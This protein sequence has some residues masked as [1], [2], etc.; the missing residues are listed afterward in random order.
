MI[1]RCAPRLPVRRRDQTC[2]MPVHRRRRLMERDR[3]QPLDHRAL[4]GGRGSSPAAPGVPARPPPRPLCIA[5]RRA[6]GAS[7]GCRSS[8][9][10]REAEGY[11]LNLRPDPKAFVIGGWRTTRKPA[12]QPVLV[13]L[14][15]NE[16]GRF[17]DGGEQV[18]G[19]P[20]HPALAAWIRPFVAAHYM[21][22][23]RNKVRRNDPFAGDARAGVRAVGDPSRRKPCRRDFPARWSRRKHGGRA[24]R[25]AGAPMPRPSR[26]A[27]RG[28]PAAG[29]DCRPAVR[30]RCAA[31]AAARD[32]LPPVESLTL[33]SDFTPFLRPAGD[34][35]LQR[36]AL[37]QAASRPA[38]QRD[39]R[40]RHVHRR[41][42]EARSDRPRS[43]AQMVQSRHIFAPPPTRVNARGH[44]RGRAA[45]GEPAP[46]DAAADRDAARDEPPDTAPTCTPPTPRAKPAATQPVA[47]PRCRRRGGRPHERRATRTAARSIPM[48]LADKHLHLC[49]CNGTMPLDAAALASALGRDARL[50]VHTRS[51]SA[52]AR[53]FA[54]DGARRRRRRL[55]AGSSGSSASWRRSGA[56]AQPIRFVNI[57]E[58]GGWST[59]ARAARCRRSPRC[60]PPPRCPSPSRCRRVSYR[61]GRAACSIIGRPTRRARRADARA[62]RSTSPCCC[63][64][65]PA[66]TLPQERALSRCTPAR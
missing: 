24:R 63:R 37:K 51:A 52:T 7:A 65:T 4:A 47:R 43:R 20:L 28:V 21:P 23:P 49:S 62:T 18:D 45:S 61:V 54:G 33:D 12:A 9:I 5:E 15:Y 10:R 60:S 64:R 16:A 19:V 41:L 57:R 11:Y 40:P 42:H 44:G 36:R 46:G 53:R 34:E 66:A 17:M 26:S 8:S 50:P 55:H 35:G 2:P 32:A 13:T 6:A 38:L 56:H 29:D 14:S 30:P 22:E 27:G 31:T 59:E 3:S 58:T 48:S 25:R 1:V 39:G